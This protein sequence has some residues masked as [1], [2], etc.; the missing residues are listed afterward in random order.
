MVYHI[1]DSSHNHRSFLTHAQKLT[2]AGNAT[3]I[4]YDEKP[5]LA[6]DPWIGERPSIFWKLGIKS[7]HTL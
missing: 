5:I 2:T 3:I 6:T 1:M 7:H 4:A